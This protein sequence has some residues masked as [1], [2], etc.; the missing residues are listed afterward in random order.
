MF[1]NDEIFSNGPLYGYVSDAQSDRL[2][3]LHGRNF[4][5]LL[6][7]LALHVA[8]VAWYQF[9]RR[10]DILRPMWTGRKPAE[11]V[12]AAEGISGHRLWLAAVLAA[13]AATILWRIVTT[14]PPASLT[15]F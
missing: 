9:A 2:T 4:D 12:P 3:G 10:V 8:A 14:A 15:P 1:A 13:L 11:R 6:L 5:R 7:L